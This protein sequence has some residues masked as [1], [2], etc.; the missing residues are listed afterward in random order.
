MKSGLAGTPSTLQGNCLEISVE[1]QTARVLVPEHLFV[2]KLQA[3][4]HRGQEQDFGDIMFLINNFEK[5][6]RESEVFLGRSVSEDDRT[7]F[8]ENYSRLAGESETRHAC[9]ILGVHY[10]DYFGEGRDKEEEG[11]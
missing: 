7:M 11:P 6:I 2:A 1:E 4:V 8:M 5:E 9:E 3:A 10:D